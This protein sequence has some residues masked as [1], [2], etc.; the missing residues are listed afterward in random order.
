MQR[1]F[2][3]L[4]DEE[5]LKIGC[6][7]HRWMT[8]WVGIVEHPYFAV[9]DADGTFTIAN[10]PAGKRTITVWHETFGTL[11]KTVDVKAGAT[12]TVDFVYPPVRRPE[13]GMFAREKRCRSAVRPSTAAACSAAGAGAS[14]STRPTRAALREQYT[15]CLCPACLAQPAP[16]PVKPQSVTSH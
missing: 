14:S 3:L 9:S 12:T 5:M 1:D 8:A 10:V 4:K 6:D 16:A 7:V 11:T 15:D 13:P 2:K